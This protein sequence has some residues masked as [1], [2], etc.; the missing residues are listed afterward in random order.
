MPVIRRVEVSS[1]K[2]RY[3]ETGCDWC[4]SPGKRPIARPNRQCS[5]RLDYATSP[6]P[7]QIPHR[8]VLDGDVQVRRRDADDDMAGGVA[9]FG[10][11][12]SAGQGVRYERAPA[13]VNGQ[14]F[15]A[16]S[17]PLVSRGRR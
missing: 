9:G 13:V 1:T 12:F 11:R 8:L 15:Q 7:K 16:S 10:E 6:R 14:R 3:W 5:L 17:M 4:K 2:Q